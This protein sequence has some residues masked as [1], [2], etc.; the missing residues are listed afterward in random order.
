MQARVGLPSVELAAEHSQPTNQPVH[1]NQHSSN[2]LNARAAIHK[3]IDGGVAADC[4]RIRCNVMYLVEE[5][6]RPGL[7][8]ERARGGQLV[9][10]GTLIGG[11]GHDAGTGTL[12]SSMA[13]RRG[14]NGGCWVG[15]NVSA[16]ARVT[17]R[18][19]GERL[20]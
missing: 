1:T 5:P 4:V 19:D 8:R 7:D 15:A 16:K 10:L 6:G 20:E 12:V 11:N 14:A 17:P 18:C 9:R 13:K 3:N 2:W